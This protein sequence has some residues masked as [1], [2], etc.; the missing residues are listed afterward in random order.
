ME[1]FNSFSEVRGHELICLQKQTI[2]RA[3][4]RQ[5]LHIFT[6]YRGRNIDWGV[7]LTATH[8]WTLCPCSPWD[9]SA[10]VGNWSKCPR[11]VRAKCPTFWDI[12][13]LLS[14]WLPH[15]VTLHRVGE[16]SWMTELNVRIRK[17][18][19]FAIGFTLHSVFCFKG[20][21]WINW[22]SL[23]TERWGD[24]V[25]FSKE[26]NIWLLPVKITIQSGFAKIGRIFPSSERN[27][28]P[29]DFKFQSISPQQVG[30]TNAGSS[31]PDLWSKLSLTSTRVV[32]P[33]GIFSS[34]Q[35]GPWRR[36]VSTM[37]RAFNRKKGKQIQ[38]TNVWA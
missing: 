34:T 3:V 22:Y 10:L 38:P 25:N 28:M 23:P 13:H 29:I 16:S 18:G 20:N 15:L 31:G 36:I 2:E 11:A 21:R 1:E 7:R 6:P 27:A 12:Y 26:L 24:F 9:C 4:T 37:N 33:G 8:S 19:A 17:S 30:K 14:K 35:E 32:P 5:T